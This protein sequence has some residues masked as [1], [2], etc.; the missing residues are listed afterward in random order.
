[1]YRVCYTLGNIKNYCLLI[2]NIFQRL[3][4]SYGLIP[5]LQVNCNN[6]LFVY[7]LFD[8]INIEDQHHL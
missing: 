4:I 1:M 8:I 6:S 3:G 7:K 5:Q 2:L